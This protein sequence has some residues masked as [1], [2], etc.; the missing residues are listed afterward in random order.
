MVVSASNDWRCT[1]LG[2]NIRVSSHEPYPAIIEDTDLESPM[3]S[4]LIPT[5]TAL[6]PM[7]YDYVALFMG[8]NYCPHCRDLAPTVVKITPILEMS[9]R[10]KVIFISCDRDAENFEQSCQKIEGIDVMP[11]DLEK[12]RDMRDLF[13][14][15]TIPAFMILQ[16]KDFDESA[17]KVV[18]N[19]RHKL[20]E[21]K[22]CFNFPWS[23]DVMPL[24]TVRNAI[25]FKERIIIQGKWGRWYHLGH[26]ANPEKP[27]AM[28]MDEHA[29]R[30]RGGVLN[31]ITWIALMNVLF[32]EQK[33]IVYT[34]FPLVF[35]E[36]LTAS[37][38]G[39]T[40]IAPIGTFSSLISTIFWSEPDWKPAKPKR[41]AWWV[42]LFMVT[43]YF[44]IFSLRENINNYKVY[45]VMVISIFNL[46]TWLESAAGFCI[47]CFIYNKFVVPAFKLEECVECKI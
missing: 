32:L 34:I 5:K 15:A 8:A 7:K 40:P 29:V 23:Q 33:A 20:T 27:E 11:Y 44:T 2:D 6:D 26:Y 46:A 3:M 16:N 24:N 19:A 17:P 10:C 4:S 18:T 31:I 21:D 35:F 42:G 45:L 22:N 12:T 13:G 37:T 41:F 36:M 25:S 47:G 1:L 28:Y 30:I 43:L 38:F 14:I 9:K 39:L